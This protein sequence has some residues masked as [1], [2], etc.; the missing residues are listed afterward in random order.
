MNIRPKDQQIKEAIWEKFSRAIARQRNVDHF[1]VDASDTLCILPIC[2]AAEAPNA[3]MLKG[4]ISSVEAKQYPWA[5]RLFHEDQDSLARWYEN[6][7]TV[8]LDRVAVAAELRKG[9]EW[10]AV[11]E[12]YMSYCN[13]DY[14]KSRT[15]K[16]LNND[17]R[18]FLDRKTK[19]ETEKNVRRSVAMTTVPTKEKVRD[20]YVFE[21]VDFLTEA[22]QWIVK[23]RAESDNSS[24]PL[25]VAV[26]YKNKFNSTL[27]DAFQH[28]A[29]ILGV[30]RHE[31]FMYQVKYELEDIPE[32]KDEMS[33]SPN[34]TPPSS[35]MKSTKS[36]SL[37]QSP[38]NENQEMI[39]IDGD[40]YKNLFSHAI[41][42]IGNNPGSLAD[43][44]FSM[45][46]TNTLEP[47]FDAVF[48]EDNNNATENNFSSN[49]RKVSYEKEA[50]ISNMN[51]WKKTKT[52]E[53]K[54]LSNTIIYD[55][56]GENF[57]P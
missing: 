21:A 14:H 29:E 33:I 45:S 44:L 20:H 9:Q 49:K 1:I 27:S 10:K 46:S 50:S 12:Q 31:L 13:N 22:R 56:Q 37:S 17:I 35:P 7:A 8:S 19:Q 30:E 36:S 52:D 26:F 32:M 43:F 16:N 53:E 11:Y 24:A 28:A 25:V 5:V 23:K 3:L 40:I 38:E 47:S 55:K 2:D 54:C 39:M 51:F 48:S 18:A 6:N 4:M 34:L 41:K 15:E 57:S 42:G